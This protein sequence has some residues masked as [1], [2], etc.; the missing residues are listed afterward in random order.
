MSIAAHVG[1]SHRPRP[2]GVR[3]DADLAEVDR[4]CR[5]LESPFPP[6]DGQNEDDVFDALKRLIKPEVLAAL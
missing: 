2:F 3:D 4:L 6:T 5:W 1:V